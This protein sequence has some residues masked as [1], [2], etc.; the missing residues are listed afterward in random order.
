MKERIS[1]IDR[2]RGLA[3]LGVVILHSDFLSDSSEMIDFLQEFFSSSVLLFFAVSGYL[4]S[5]KPKADVHKKSIYLTKKYL[6]FLTLYASFFLILFK[7]NCVSNLESIIAPQI[8]FL[9]Y[10]AFIQVATEYVVYNGKF[11]HEIICCA[12]LLFIILK[13]VDVLHGSGVNQFIL[14]IL[15][16]GVMK[17]IRSSRLKLILG[18]VFMFVIILRSPLTLL[19]LVSILLIHTFP[20]KFIEYIGVKSGAI[21]IWHTPLLMPIY[22][23][24]VGHNNL[25]NPFYYTVLIGLTIGSSLVIAKII[26]KRNIKY[27]KI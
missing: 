1:F 12:L 17:N 22:A 4:S 21:F 2:T 20:I 27:L 19:F 23:R 25:S 18:F 16:Y 13:P 7:T 10:L 5:G 26:E 9:I 3:I 24:I 15:S 8:Y 11:T 14:Y 6:I